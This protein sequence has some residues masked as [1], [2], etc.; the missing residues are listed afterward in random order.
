MH[1]YMNLNLQIDKE[2]EQTGG[3]C[4]ATW[5]NASC[6]T[7][8]TP[9]FD[10]RDFVGRLSGRFLSV[11]LGFVVLCSCARVCAC[12]ACLFSLHSLSFFLSFSVSLSLSLSFSLPLSLSLSFAFSLSLLF[13][14]Y[15]SLSL[16]LSLSLPSF[17]PLFFSLTFSL[18][19]PRV[20][21]RLQTQHHERTR[22]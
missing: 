17:L 11:C 7:T 15:L 14:F 19:R 12:R 3:W 20:H 6:S 9:R 18:P 5:S 13:S 10:S 22:I 21:V 2:V 4:T 1:T 16:F 8:Q